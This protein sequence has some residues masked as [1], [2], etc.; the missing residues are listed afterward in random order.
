MTA[1]RLVVRDVSDH[2]IR[3]GPPHDQ[4]DLSSVPHASVNIPMVAVV[5]Q[6]CELG[7]WHDISVTELPC[8]GA[9]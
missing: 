8:W 3:P 5:Q 7:C 2:S 6:K 1:R 9:P 4:I